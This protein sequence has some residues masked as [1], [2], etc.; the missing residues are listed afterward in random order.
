[1]KKIVYKTNVTKL[2]TNLL[3]II[4]LAAVS[5]ALLYSALSFLNE[6]GK[7][8]LVGFIV[9]FAIASFV[10]RWLAKIINYTL[11]NTVYFI[12]DSDKL[13]K[14]YVFRKRTETCYFTDITGY[15]D[16]KDYYSSRKQ[17]ISFYL[18]DGRVL[19]IED[20]TI[21]DFHRFKQKLTKYNFNYLGWN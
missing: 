19:D 8:G 18:S 7:T 12:I 16:G 10:F 1:M 17:K 13:T 6:G 21:K 11:R 2:L 3:K 5:L 20:D 14:L 9:L 15:S 4:I